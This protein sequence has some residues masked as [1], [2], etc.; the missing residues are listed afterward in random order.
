MEFR[1]NEVRTL[2]NNPKLTIGDVTTANLTIMKGG[3]QSNVVPPE[4][5]IVFDFRIPITR[6][7]K[8]FEA[9]VRLPFAN[10]SLPVNAL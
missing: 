6:D 5:T 2:E 1:A 10:Y 7:L 4:L 3:V 9:M 8:E